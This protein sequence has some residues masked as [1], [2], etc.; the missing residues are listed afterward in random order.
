MFNSTTT[1]DTTSDSFYKT[2]TPHAGHSTVVGRD[3]IKYN[4]KIGGTS[5]PCFLYS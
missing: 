4:A 5:Y 3:I 2:I 1:V